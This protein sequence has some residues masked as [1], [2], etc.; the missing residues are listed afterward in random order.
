MTKREME[1]HKMSNGD[2]IGA[3]REAKRKRWRRLG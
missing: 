3:D 2:M 1:I